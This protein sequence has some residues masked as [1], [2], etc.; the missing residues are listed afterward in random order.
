MMIPSKLTPMIPV[1][2]P[3]L[4]P[5]EGMTVQALKQRCQQAHIEEPAWINSQ[6]SPLSAIQHS[7]QDPTLCP[8]DIP[9]KIVT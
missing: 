3:V 5:E 6:E 1:T 2:G 9:A 4:S 7:D 8:G